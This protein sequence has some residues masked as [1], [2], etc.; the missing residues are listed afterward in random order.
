MANL[1]PILSFGLNL[2]ILIVS[3]AGFLKIMKNDLTHLQRD[4]TAIKSQHE[5]TDEKLDN[6]S[7]RVATI[8]GKL[9]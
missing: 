1:I 8:E 3:I 6:L 5:K 2:L 9:Q 7:E 4:V